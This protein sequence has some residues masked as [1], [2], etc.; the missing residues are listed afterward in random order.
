MTLGQSLLGEKFVWVVVVGGLKV[1]LVLALVKHSR[2]WAFDW[3]LDQAKQQLSM[4]T[5][6][7]VLEYE[8][9]HVNTLFY[10]HAN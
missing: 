4:Y 3:D 5:P 9:A 7:V 10:L 6:S 8:S 2:I 1:S